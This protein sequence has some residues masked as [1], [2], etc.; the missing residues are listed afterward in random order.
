ME[1]RYKE[2]EQ[3]G[4]RNIDAHNRIFLS[5]KPEKK[6]MG[7]RM[8]YMPHIVVV[9]DELGDLMSVAKAEVEESIQRIAQK[10][11]AVGIHLVLATQRPS[12]KVITGVIKA[13]LPARVAFRVS[14]KVDSRVIIDEMG[15]A[16]LLGNGDLLFSTGS[17]EGPQRIQ[18]AFIADD[19]VER[20][21][22]HVLAQ[23][24][25]QY[26]KTDFTAK[27]AKN[28]EEAMGDDDFLDA[29]LSV[30]DLMEDQM[31]RRAAI[32]ILENRKAS[33]SLIQRRLKIGFAR[34]GRL[35]DQMEQAGIV[36]PYLGSK[37]R[38]IMGDPQEWLDRLRAEE[39]A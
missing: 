1:D 23:E 20:L 34:A 15:A 35:M 22:E 13:N 32:L 24:K 33:V 27:S 37:P 28:A 10:A 21:C 26:M 36:G 3:V 39:A 5:D 31:F 4:V 7:R 17:A 9:I 6:A 30:D 2:L 14:Q 8:K 29:D 19:E 18:G 16:E 11:R 38:E 12:V 25:A